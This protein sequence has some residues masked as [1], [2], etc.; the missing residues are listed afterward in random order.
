MTYSF[1]IIEVFGMLSSFSLL[2]TIW[3]QYEDHFIDKF[4]AAT[5]ELNQSLLGIKDLS[6]QEASKKLKS[7]Q[8][9]ISIYDKNRNAIQKISDTELLSFKKHSLDFFDTFNLVIEDL[10]DIAQIHSSLQMSMPVLEED[11]NSQEDQHWDSY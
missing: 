10:E 1:N 7:L 6:P 2:K 3:R 9:V 4:R 5:K 11:W 8:I